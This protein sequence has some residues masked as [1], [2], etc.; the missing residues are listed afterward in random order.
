MSNIRFRYINIK[1]EDKGGIH[2][3]KKLPAPDYD[4]EDRHTSY[5]ARTLQVAIEEVYDKLNQIERVICDTP[6]SIV[7]PNE[8]ELGLVHKTSFGNIEVDFTS[9]TVE[10]S[11]TFS[12]ESGSKT[13]ESV[14]HLLI[15]ALDEGSNSEVHYA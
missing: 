12:V 9:K 5:R 14:Y 8:V 4:K 15:F 7:S 11:I 10:A 6:S 2:I 1:A 3:V 13:P